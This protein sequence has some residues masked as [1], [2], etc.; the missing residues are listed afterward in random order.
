MTIM[1]YIER[2]EYEVWC[3]SQRGTF[4]MSLKFLWYLVKSDL[5]YTQW[6]QKK[7]TKHNFDMQSALHKSHTHWS[8]NSQEDRLHTKPPVVDM[9]SIIISIHTSSRS[10]YSIGY[11]PH[12]TFITASTSQVF[13]H[14][15]SI[16]QWTNR[17]K[18]I[19]QTKPSINLAY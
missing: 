8:C 14:V 5:E 11:H 2:I 19:R 13:A 15:V 12:V 16:I 9:L 7:M 18:G 1:G 3:L 4:A 10:W 6:Y 17:P